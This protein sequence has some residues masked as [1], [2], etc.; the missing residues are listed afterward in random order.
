MWRDGDTARAG[1][2]APKVCDPSGS[3]LVGRTIAVHR[4]S[5]SAGTVV[6]QETVSVPVMSLWKSQW[7]S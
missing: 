4:A 2:A 6:T 5:S 7:N 3:G 1:G